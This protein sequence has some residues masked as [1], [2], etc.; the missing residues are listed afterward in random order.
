MESVN[1]LHGQGRD[2]GLRTQTLHLLASLK[3]TVVTLCQPPSNGEEAKAL[4]ELNPR[5]SNSN[6]KSREKR[7]VP[8]S[9]P[10]KTKKTSNTKKKKKKKRTKKIPIYP[11]MRSI[12]QRTPPRQ[13]LVRL[14]GE[15]HTAKM[16]TKS[17]YRRF[18]SR[19]ARIRL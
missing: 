8:T 7:I 14:R 10:R 4:R 1:P 11:R 15:I 3:A 5:R 17:S 9:K 16:M 12:R 6:N 2:S 19:S 13:P 18:L